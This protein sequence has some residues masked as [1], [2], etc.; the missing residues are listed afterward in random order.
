M[1]VVFVSLKKLA[2]GS[3]GLGGDAWE[4]HEAGIGGLIGDFVFSD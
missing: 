2:D 3:G 4:G 1:M